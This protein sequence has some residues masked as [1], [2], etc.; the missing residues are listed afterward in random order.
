MCDA[1]VINTVKER[2]LS[3]REFFKTTAAAAAGVAA[4][5]AAP[6]SLPVAAAGGGGW[7]V[8]DLTHTTS[9]DFPTFGGVPTFAKK[10]LYNYAENKF[11]MFDITVNE[12]TGTHIDAPLHFSADG[13]SVDAIPVSKLI[14][15]LCI[16]DI[17]AKA[18]ANADA[19]LT[20]DDLRAW[21]AQHGEIPDG[22]CVAMNSGWDAHV[23]SAKYRGAD[24]DGK[25]HFPGFHVESAAYL[26]E[27]TTAVGI[28]VDTLSQDYGPSPDFAFH[29]AWL[30]HN[31]WGLECVA[32]LSALP[33]TGATI[34]AGAPK[35]AG[36]SGGPTRIF[37]LA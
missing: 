28:A 7:S 27:E 32:N 26:L 13:W 20:P 14:A 8:S 30:P 31:R 11:N 2:M 37:A 35:F 21:V 5:T 23:N 4:A 1:H 25:L 6:I 16:V 12:H 9:E 10:Q 19:Q 22:A 34:I 24:A 15:P 18:A 3:R 33:A 17:R 29:Y 36:G